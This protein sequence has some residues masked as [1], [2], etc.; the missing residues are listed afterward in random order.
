MLPSERV[1]P[2]LV[3]FEGN[4]T[5]L[6][7][8]VSEITKRNTLA[9]LVTF[10]GRIGDALY[11]PEITELVENLCFCVAHGVNPFDSYSMA[12]Y[13]AQWGVWWT[14]RQVSHPIGR[15]APLF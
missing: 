10:V 15:L 3:L 5:I 2:G 6:A 8:H 11:L 9:N 1:A 4:V 13:G 7:E 12:P 14:L